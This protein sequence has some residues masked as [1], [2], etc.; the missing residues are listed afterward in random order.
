[1]ITVRG[2]AKL[3]NV[4]IGTVDRVLHNRGHVAKETRKIVEDVIREQNYRPNFFARSLKR[5]QHFNFTVL[6]PKMEQ[7]NS[8]W[9]LIKFGMDKA[10][11]EL[12]EY[13]IDV[14]VLE[15]DR[16]S[17][18]SFQV[19][20][21]KI[22]L[23]MPD[24]LILVPVLSVDINKFL[25]QIPQK[26]PYIFVDSKIDNSSQISY[27]GHHPYESGRLAG[28][29]M[30]LLAGDKKGTFAVIRSYTQ[31]Y[32]MAKRAAGFHAFFNGNDSFSLVDYNIQGIEDKKSYEDIAK[33]CI[34]HNPDLIGIFITN[35][36]ANI[37]ANYILNSNLQKRPFLIGYD[38][39]EEN[40]KFLKDGVIDF[41]ISH[42]P[43][44]QGYNAIMQLYDYVV[45]KRDIEV[46]PK[47]P[48]DIL[49]KEN[50]DFLNFEYWLKGIP[51]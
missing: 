17:E 37:V 11:H 2:I 47:I 10:I 38:L 27:I 43:D 25:S 23:N 6:M 33:R 19:Q 29:L 16:N 24:G 34:D 18:R 7:D 31:E 9:R 49:T 36:Y 20:C 46:E 51:V 22:R 12:Q 45:L 39:V 3:A 4:S 32:H 41:L 5:G 42:R 48:I 21:Q 40:I 35:V 13:N 14:T 1:M 50:I 8:F 15:F 30:K 44:M 26:V 28:K